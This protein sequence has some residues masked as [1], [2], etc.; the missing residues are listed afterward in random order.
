M[1]ELIFVIV[2]LGILSAVALPKFIGV[3][4]QARV[5]KLQAYVGTLDRTTLPPYWSNSLASGSGGSVTG[6]AS[7]IVS[8]L[9]A[10]D[11]ITV[12]FAN[13]N[14]TPVDFNGTVIGTTTIVGSKAY[15]GITYS[16]VCNDGNS[17][18]SAMCD[19][20]NSSTGKYMLNA[21]R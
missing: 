16:I 15:N 20:F 18:S 21:N 19:L 5:G 9:P 4:D 6:F 17:T 7:N 2:I 3:A 1:I 14:S 11:N 12:N 8:D 10:P 13:M